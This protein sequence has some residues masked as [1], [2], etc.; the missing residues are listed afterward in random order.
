[1]IK[2]GRRNTARVRPDSGVGGGGGVERP[3]PGQSV[4]RRGSCYVSDEDG[5]AGL[6]RRMRYE[7]GRKQQKRAR[8]L[9][10]Q[11]GAVRSRWRPPVAAAAAA[12]A[13]T[14]TATA[15][16]VGRP[17]HGLTWGYLVAVDIHIHGMAWP[18]IDV[19]FTCLACFPPPPTPPPQS[20]LSL[21]LRFAGIKKMGESFRHR[22]SIWP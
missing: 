10:S 6:G 1:M 16:L 19:D 14:A 12:A 5:Y 3:G 9:I 21:F 2:R 7:T 8:L 13:A 15:D 22:K 4:P 17:S 18:A 11:R 20:C